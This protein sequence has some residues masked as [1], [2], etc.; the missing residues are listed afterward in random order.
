MT[1]KEEEEGGREEGRVEWGRRGE[2]GED[3]RDGGEQ[4]RVFLSHLGMFACSKLYAHMERGG[5]G[6]GGGGQ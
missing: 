5:G 4:G 6:G 3:G 1:W 2:G